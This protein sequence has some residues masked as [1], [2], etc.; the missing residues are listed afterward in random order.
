MFSIKFYQPS[1][2]QGS[3]FANSTGSSRRGFLLS[4]SW[5]CDGRL[6]VDRV[7]IP[8]G[9]RVN[10]SSPVTDELLCLGCPTILTGNPEMLPGA[11]APGFISV[12]AQGV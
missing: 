3:C 2:A 11:A 8:E 9:N 1:L 5:L 7:T 12:V 4:E 10:G 6:S